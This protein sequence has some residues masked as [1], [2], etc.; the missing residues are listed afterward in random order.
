MLIEDVCEYLI[1]Y[2]LIY[3]QY[4]LFKNLMYP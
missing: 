1:L 2:N 4:N 3:C